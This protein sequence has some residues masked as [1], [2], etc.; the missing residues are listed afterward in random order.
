[1]LVGAADIG[2]QYSQDDAVIALTFSQR[3]FRESDCLN[4]NFTRAF[5]DNTT[6]GIVA[7]HGNT[8]VIFLLEHLKWMDWIQY[9]N[10]NAF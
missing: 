2:S 1:M 8:P 10:K 3:K 7:T 6:V 4:G 5:I 9:R